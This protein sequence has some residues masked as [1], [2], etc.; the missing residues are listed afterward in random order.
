MYICVYV[1]MQLCKY[2]LYNKPI[3]RYLSDYVKVI[4]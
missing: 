1:I 4:L 2:I 3:D